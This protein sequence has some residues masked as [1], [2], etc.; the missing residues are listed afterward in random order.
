MAGIGLEF[1]PVS[2]DSANV[3][4]VANDGTKFRAM[5]FEAPM[6]ERS[7]NWS[8]SADTEG[9]LPANLRYQN[10]KITAE[11]RIY[12][13]SA[14]NLMEE[15]GKLEQKVGRVNTPSEQAT[16]KWTGASGT[17][18]IFDLLE[19]EVNTVIDNPALAT[20]RAVVTASFTAKPFW[21]S[22]TEVEGSLHEETTLPFVIGVDTSIGGDVPPLGRLVITEKQA[23]DQWTLIWGTQSRYYDS[24]ANAELFYQ[25]E[26]RTPT[27]G[28]EKKAGPSGASGAGENTIFNGSLISTYQSVMSTQAAGGGAHLSNIGV[29]R[30]FARIQRPTTNTGKVSIALSYAQGDFQRYTT[31]TAKTYAAD[32]LEGVW[33]LVDLG[34]VR[35]T[36]VTAGTQRWEGRLLAKSTVAGDDIYVDCFGLFPVDEGYGSLKIE[37]TT[38]LPTTIA[39]HDEFEQGAGNLEGKT[40]PSGQTWAEFSKTGENGFKVNASKWAERAKVSDADLNSGCYAFVGTTKFI[41]TYLG[42]SVEADE[43]T[44]T[45]LRLGLIARAL[46]VEPEKNCVFC[47]V[48]QELDSEFHLRNFLRV[49]KRIGGTNTTLESAAIGGK[50]LEEGLLGSDWPFRITFQVNTRG[51]WQALAYKTTG[52]AGA[53][54]GLGGATF[55]PSAA[56]SGRIEGQDS[57]LAAGG[58][59]AEGKVGIYD[60]WSSA[61]VNTRVVD[62]FVA[63]EGA[64]SDAAVFASKKAEIRWDRYQREDS[65]GTLLVPRTDY[66]GGYFRPP[67]ARREARSLRTIVKLSRYNIDTMAD[68]A[69][70]DAAFRIFWQARG[71]LLPES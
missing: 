41:N 4:L 5:K 39:A 68:A 1:D 40:L 54:R 49:I 3:P 17:S 70:D 15:L 27:S 23:V 66:K 59:L 35:I 8:S 19:A 57:S 62:D 55:T 48:E 12:G 52:K 69:I 20:N 2:E 67:P 14:A 38:A 11:W 36:K 45:K 6:P 30:V 53:L 26:S 64:P 37:P 28:S 10:R 58:T 32:E 13:S 22:G 61:G 63:F 9:E 46:A 25:A 7:V 44:G 43:Y 24:S 18:C 65:G 71:L 56:P 16:L 51:Q 21:R 60:A 34:L 50:S 47:V 33:T 31:N 42:V 29:F